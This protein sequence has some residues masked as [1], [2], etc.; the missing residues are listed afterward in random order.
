MVWMDSL[1]IMMGILIVC[2]GIGLS[3]TPCLAGERYLSDGPDFFVSLGSTSELIPGATAELPVTIGNK[4]TVTLELYT[5]LSMQPMYLPTTAKS[6]IIEL[7]PGDA[8][9]LVRSNPQIMGEVQ[10]GQI[11]PATFTVEIPQAAPAGN[12]TMLARINYSYVPRIEQQGSADMTYYFKE[13]ETV[14]PVPI[15][16]RQMV[17]IAVEKVESNNLSAG[18]EGVI[19]FTIRNTGQ[20]TG[21]GTSLFLVP[22]ESS[23]IVPFSNSVYIGEFPPE[24]IIQPS[25]KVAVSGEAAP[26]L[27]YP[28]SLYAAYK[29]FTGAAATSPSVT[30]GVSFQDKISFERVNT[31][32]VVNPGTKGTVR[33]TYKNTGKSK[34]YN[35]KARIS[36]I[37]PFSSDDDTAYLGDLG[38]G[39]SAT[40][41]FSVKTDGKAMV[42]MYSADSEVQYT[43]E[44]G[45]VYTSDN[46]PVPI[47]VQDDPTPRISRCGPYDTHHRGR[48]VSLVPPEKDDRVPRQNAMRYLV[49]RHCTRLMAAVLL[50]IT[51][52]AAPC[53]AL[54]YTYD[55]VLEPVL[56][57]H[58]VSDPR[59]YPGDTFAMTV[60][61]SNKD[62]DTS[63]QIAPL[64]APPDIYDPR[65]ALGLV[66]SQRESDAPVNVKNLPV[67]VGDIRP[68]DKIP[69]TIQ[70]TV[71]EKALPGTRT[72][73]LNLTYRY[74]YTI[75]KIGSGDSTIQPLYR[76]RSLTLPIGITI[77]SEVRP[78]RPPR[79]AGEPRP[80][81][82]GIPDW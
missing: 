51:M 63:V 10:A 64:L 76:E 80:G 15:K 30:A 35:A 72:I 19:N 39:E 62:Q 6:T 26:R 57:A 48:C 60:V 33:V 73:L 41:I 58:V 40:A 5:F 71:N 38:P 75:T 78:A 50:C 67:L 52:S 43:D 56:S 29:D 3:I 16:I 36:V 17:I 55:P 12:Y 11:V 66:V 4:G 1:R 77:N 69:L 61:L 18:S 27:S 25:F 70:G 54:G 59:Y 68:G 14:L 8:P 31:S 22:A 82:P 24:S 9:V 42:K 65:T 32:S 49:L 74:I 79:D 44:S 7:L 21:I 20:D 45:T 47:D 13:E 37:N 2:I 46:I 23:P 28:L 53:I 81:D 34:V